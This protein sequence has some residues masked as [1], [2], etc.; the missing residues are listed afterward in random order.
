MFVPLA[1]GAIPC[2]VVTVLGLILAAVASSPEAQP[3]TVLLQ[4]AGVD[5][6]HDVLVPGLG[7]VWAGV[8]VAVAGGPGEGMGG[9][10]HTQMHNDGGPVE[11][12]LLQLT[13]VHTRVTRLGPT[14]QNTS[15]CHHQLLSRLQLIQLRAVLSCLFVP[16]HGRMSGFGQALQV[17]AVTLCNHHHPLFCFHLQTGSLYDTLG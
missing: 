10:P 4:A 7:G 16:G 1:P 17:C 11:A 9:A 5:E 3:L 6:G 13:V 14:D 2:L 12:V 15:L 8:G